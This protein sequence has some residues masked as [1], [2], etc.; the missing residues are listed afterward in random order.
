MNHLDGS[1]SFIEV[2]LSSHELNSGTTVKAT[3]SEVNSEYVTVKANGSRNACKLPRRR[4]I[5]RNTATV[6]IVDEVIAL[7]TSPVALIII[8]REKGSFCSLR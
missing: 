4:P 2:L 1:C 3:T 5:G 8:S 6:A 7:A